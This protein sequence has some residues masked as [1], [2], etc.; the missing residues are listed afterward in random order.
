MRTVLFLISLSLL[1]SN[2]LSAQHIEAVNERKKHSNSEKGREIFEHNSKQHSEQKRFEMPEHKTS[3]LLIEH[4]GF[5]LLYNEL[6]EQAA[7]VAYELTAEETHKAYK[8]TDHFM[9]DPKVETGTA[10]DLDYNNSGYDRGHLAPASDMGWSSTT[11]A[12]SFFYSNMSPQ[13]P[14][15][16]RGIWKK[17]EDLVRTW[18][19]ENEALYVV[20]GPVLS[21]GLETIG[22]NKVSVP[23]LYY[24]VILDYREPERKGIAFLMPNEGSNEALSSFAVS[25]DSIQKVTGINFFPLLPDEEEKELE[26]NVCLGCWSW[27]SKRQSSNIHKRSSSAIVEPGNPQEHPSFLTAPTNPDKS[28]KHHHAIV[29]AQCAGVTKKGNQCKRMTKSSNGFCWQH[30][31]D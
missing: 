12:E 13:V 29:S 3:D 21:N 28:A 11:M 23:K 16:N 7:W 25:I 2:M 1:F 9:V 27:K 15:F 14:A 10:E 20:T 24:K 8:R 19:I 6:H 4:T 31:G 22:P 17:G 26:S 30:G 18:A 5:A